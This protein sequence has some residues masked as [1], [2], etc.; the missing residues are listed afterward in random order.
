MIGCKIYQKLPIGNPY[1]PHQEMT[2][3]QLT[4]QDRQR[5]VEL[6][7]IHQPTIDLLKEYCI[8]EW[9]KFC[10]TLIRDAIELKLKEE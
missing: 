7:A 5:Y 6:T 10:I 4:N 2:N 9:A 8:E 3:K 1:Q